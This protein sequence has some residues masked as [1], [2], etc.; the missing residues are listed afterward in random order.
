MWFTFEKMKTSM[1]KEKMLIHVLA[2][3]FQSIDDS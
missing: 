1:E 3:F 2:N